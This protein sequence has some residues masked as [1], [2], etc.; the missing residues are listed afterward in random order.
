MPRDYTYVIVTQLLH[1]YFC[2]ILNQDSQS[3]LNE[4]NMAFYENE[5]GTL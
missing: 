2:R 3:D 5:R 1:S 4:R